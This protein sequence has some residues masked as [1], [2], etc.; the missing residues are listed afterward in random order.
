M[1]CRQHV[2]VEAPADLRHPLGDRHHGADR[3]SAAGPAEQLDIGLA[4][5]R[6]R[7]G[8]VAF[9]IE[10]ESDLALFEPFLLDDGLE[11][12]VLVGEI[13]VKRA[14]GDAGR[15]RA[16][17]PMLAPSKPRSMKTLRA[18]SRIWRRFEL[19]SSL[20]RRS[21]VGMGCNHWFSFSGRIPR[22]ASAA[23]ETRR[24]WSDR[25]NVP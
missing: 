18:P 1:V 25:Q 16:I 7:R 5:L 2:L 10:I 19:S 12:P 15:T 23:E 17:S 6:Q 9:G 22:P 24:L 4:E 11:Q 3:R 14:L 20:D 13:D 8:D 21:V